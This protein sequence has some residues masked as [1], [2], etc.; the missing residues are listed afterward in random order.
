[1]AAI[2]TERGTALLIVE[3]NANLALGVASRAYVLEAGTIVNEGSAADL[4]GDESIRRAYL[5]S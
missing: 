2:S 1:V 3:Q 5:G 4:Q